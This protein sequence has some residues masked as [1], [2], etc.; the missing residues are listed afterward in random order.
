MEKR[1]ARV[2]K[3]GNGFSMHCEILVDRKTGVNYLYC[4]SGYSGG[5]SVLLDKDGKPVVSSP[6]ELWG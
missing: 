5:L 2:Y 3:E 4:Q 6:D 1:F